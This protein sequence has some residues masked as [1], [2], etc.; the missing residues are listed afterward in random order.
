M[1]GHG[2]NLEVKCRALLEWG[3]GGLGCDV[4]DE[5]RSREPE[6]PSQRAHPAHLM[7][8][9]NIQGGIQRICTS[10]TPCSNKMM[11]LKCPLFL[12][13]YNSTT[14]LNIQ[15]L[16]SDR[17]T[18]SV[19]LGA[20]AN[21]TRIINLDYTEQKQPMSSKNQSAP[22]CYFCVSVPCDDSEDYQEHFR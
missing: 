6:I 18:S 11:S 13:G 14:I 1:G 9:R 16:R 2:C 21:H 17:L 10:S 8:H 20:P 15:L 19:H 12:N 3:V 4:R 5:N 7:S 22:W